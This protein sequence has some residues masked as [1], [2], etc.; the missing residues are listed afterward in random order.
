MGDRVRVLIADDSPFMRRA[1]ERMLSSVPEIEI[2]GDAA[3]GTQ[4]VAM[5]KQL[6]P[7][8][9]I[10]DVNMPEMDGLEALR[11]IMAEAPT[12]VL[13]LSTLTSEGTRTTMNALELGAVD[14]LDKGAPGTAMDIYGLA[15]QLREKVLAVA[16]ATV[17]GPSPLRELG[18]PPPSRAAHPPRVRRATSSCPYDLVVIGASTGGP[19]AVSEVLTSLPAEFGAGIVV[20]QHMPPGFTQTLA[21]RLDRRSQLS[22]REARDGDEV[23]PGEVLISP[24]GVHLTI[25]RQG[26]K[27][28]TRLDSRHSELLHRPS[29]NRLFESAAEACGAGTIGV[30]LTGMGDDGS[31]G[32]ARIREVGGRTVA[33]S[34]ETAIIFGMPRAA[35][36]AAERVLPLTRVAPHL[37][38]LCAA[39]SRETEV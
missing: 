39:S 9:V 6:S 24:G 2:V 11:A 3:T 16:G 14:F 34:E 8:V 13:M 19:R 5:T 20:A 12:G 30:V 25:E 15:P 4:A 26:S 28:I 22:I 10:L 23:R 21:D 38:A 37:V 35:A 31:R 27:L 32:L 33:E 29:V 18:S 17:H 1:V 7:D 36:P